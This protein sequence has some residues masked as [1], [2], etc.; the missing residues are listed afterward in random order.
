MALFAAPVCGLVQSER[1]A[2]APGTRRLKYRDYSASGLY[3]VTICSD[4][5]R[6]IF[7]EVEKQKVTLSALGRIAEEAWTALPG[8]HA[9]IRLH[10]HVV[11][12]NHV[13]GIIEIVSEE[14][15]LQAAP[16]Q[17]GAGGVGRVPLLSVVVRSF[18]ADVTRRAAV[19]LGRGEE[20]AE[21]L[22]RSRDSGQ[23]RVFECDEIYRGESSAMGS[24][25]I[26]EG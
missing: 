4:F 1:R 18:K 15:A 12:P 7:G 19:E 23:A 17:R 14:V 5:K 13:H 22:L 9:D 24:P 21:E 2:V 25:E 26:A 16:L 8:R 3:F 10:E 6:C 11:M 20:M